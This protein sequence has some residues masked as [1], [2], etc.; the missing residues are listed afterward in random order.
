M[1]EDAAVVGRER[2]R[3][4]AELRRN[5]IDINDPLFTSNKTREYLGDISEMTLWRWQR[6]IEFPMHDFVFG[7]R[8]FWRKS[9]ID[10]WLTKMK[11]KQRDE[12]LN[13]LDR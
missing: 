8:R 2:R 3:F 6:E 10:S 7:K 13:A 9:T 5:S 12:L 11:Q 4:A 1:I